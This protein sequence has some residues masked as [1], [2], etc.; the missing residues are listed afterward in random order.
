MSADELRRIFAGCLHFILQPIAP[1]LKWAAP[2]PGLV[3]MPGGVLVY[4]RELAPNQLGIPEL[5]AAQFEE[6]M[7]R[8]TLDCNEEP[9]MEPDDVLVFARQCAQYFYGVDALSPPPLVER[10]YFALPAASR[11]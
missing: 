8:V 6:H 4:Q 10:E 1:T 9:S 5:I 3:L 7:R 2:Y 11:N